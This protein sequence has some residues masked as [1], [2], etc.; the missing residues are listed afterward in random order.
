MKITSECLLKADPK[1]GTVNISKSYLSESGLALKETKSIHCESDYVSG[2][3]YRISGDN[4]KTF[5]DWMDAP[6][7]ERELSFGEDELIV[8]ESPRLWNPIHKHYVY[9]RFLRYFIG[10]HKSAYEAYWKRGERAFFD[11]QY[12]AISNELSGECISKKLVMYEDGADFDPKN[13]RN[14]EFLE[15]N[16]GFLNT[17]SVLKCGDIVVP[18]GAPVRVGCKIA[19]L[20]VSRV[21]PSAPDIMRCVIVARGKFNEKSG[22]Y[23]FTFSNPVILGDLRSSRGIDEPIITELSS[24]RL[25]LVMRG[26]NVQS[27]SWGTRIEDGTPSF[28][29]YSYSDD[30]GKSFTEPEP[31]RFDDREVIYSSATISNFVRS[32]KNGRLYWIG[33]ITDNTACG[34]FP[35][36]PLNIAEVDEELGV[37]KKDTLAVIDTKRE[38]E[39]NKVQLSNFSVF[40]DR[41]TGNLEITLSKTH[42]FDEKIPFFG[43]TWRYTIDFE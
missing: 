12:I 1:S 11:H 29:W 21:F 16:I 28:K 25:L 24:S 5:G 15:R 13:P 31:W 9:T 32:S 20:D 18:V 23:D 26:S 42:Q 8:S 39:T 33:N 37:L 3:Q 6:R 38:G 35:R 2:V 34:N 41:E 36:Y 17:P 10:G 4:G 27:A 30:G 40:E 19:G 7:K 22:E 43:E 14:P